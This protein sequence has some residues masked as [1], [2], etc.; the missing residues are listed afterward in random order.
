VTIFRLFLFSNAVR[1]ELK[2]SLILSKKKEMVQDWFDVHSGIS[3]FWSSL[4]FLKLLVVLCVLQF[5][6]GVM[7]FSES[8]PAPHEMGVFVL[9]ARDGSYDLVQTF[10]VKIPLLRTQSSISQNLLLFFSHSFRLIF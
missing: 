3:L 5:L 8:H 4:H 6:P 2:L 1:A 9:G 7:W 10:V